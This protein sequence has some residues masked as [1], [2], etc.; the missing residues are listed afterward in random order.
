MNRCKTCRWWEPSDHK[1]TPQGYREC[2]LTLTSNN[3]H[4]YPQTLAFSLDDEYYAALLVTAPDFGCVQWEQ[5]EDATNEDSERSIDV[6]QGNGDG[7]D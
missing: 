3:R 5:K 4:E 6:G 2:R 1:A 7:D